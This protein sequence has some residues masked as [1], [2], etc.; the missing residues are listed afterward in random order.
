[1]SRRQVLRYGISLK[2]SEGHQKIIFRGVRSIQIRKRLLLCE[3]CETVIELSQYVD[4]DDWPEDTKFTSAGT[5]DE[6]IRAKIQLM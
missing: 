2:N 6:E 1:M 5:K 4:I 3:Q